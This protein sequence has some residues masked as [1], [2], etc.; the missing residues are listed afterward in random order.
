MPKGA[1]YFCGGD[2][3]AAWTWPTYVVGRQFHPSSCEGPLEFVVCKF[4][5]PLP[6][7]PSGVFVA[8]VSVPGSQ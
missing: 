4:S 5:T 7:Y 6:R 8:S 2:A 3:P 1:N